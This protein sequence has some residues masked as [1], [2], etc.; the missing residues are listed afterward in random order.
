ML[1]EGQQAGDQIGYKRVESR[2][3][4]GFN[5][6]VINKMNYYSCSGDT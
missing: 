5:P 2:P 4:G 6:S 3:L 1:K